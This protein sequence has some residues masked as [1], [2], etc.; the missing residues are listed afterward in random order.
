MIPATPSNPE[1]NRT[2]VPGSGVL[3]VPGADGN[4]PNEMSTAVI[5][6]L[7]VTFAAVIVNVPV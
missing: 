2:S 3:F 7:V 4:V 1:P 6:E 5:V